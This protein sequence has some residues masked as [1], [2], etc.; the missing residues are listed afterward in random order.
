MVFADVFSLCVVLVKIMGKPKK[1]R[2]DRRKKRQFYGNRFTKKN[3]GSERTDRLAD[4]D[5]ETEQACGDVQPSTSTDIP[6]AQNYS[7]PSAAKLDSRL[8]E[9]VQFDQEEALTGFR[10]VDCENLIDF[11]SE[12]LCPNCKQPLGTNKRLFHVTRE[13]NFYG[14]TVHLSL[15]V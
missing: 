9:S 11:V 15:P 14:I 3:I 12:W 6:V 7:T 2:A 1:V 13:E 5:P 8:E 10:F 4:T